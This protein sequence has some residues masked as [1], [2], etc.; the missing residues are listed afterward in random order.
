[1]GIMSTTLTFNEDRRLA[2]RRLIH[3]RRIAAESRKATQ[4]VESSQRATNKYDLALDFLGS[5][6]A[7]VVSFVVLIFTGLLSGASSI[8]V[9]IVLIV[10]IVCAFVIA[11][12]RSFYS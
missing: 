1:M 9:Q 8:V 4:I 11:F 3:K 6:L 2:E 12:R 7:V 5:I 10:S